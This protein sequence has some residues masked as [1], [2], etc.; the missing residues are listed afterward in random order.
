MKVSGLDAASVE[1]F[2]HGVPCGSKIAMEVHSNALTLREGCL[3]E[4]CKSGSTRK[5]SLRNQ[6]T[7]GK[8]LT[9]PLACHANWV[10][11]YCNRDQTATVSQCK[12]NA[13]QDLASCGKLFGTRVSVLN[14]ERKDLSLDHMIWHENGIGYRPD[15]PNVRGF[16]D[17]ALKNKSP[18]YTKFKPPTWSP[19]F[20]SGFQHA[21]PVLI[22]PK[23]IRGSKSFTIKLSPFTDASGFF[24]MKGS[25]CYR[26]NAP[27]SHVEVPFFDDIQREVN[28]PKGS[29]F[30]LTFW[31]KPPFEGQ[32]CATS[33]VQFS[34]KPPLPTPETERRARTRAAAQKA[35]ADKAAAQKAAAQKA[36]ADK[37]AADKA[38]AD[39]A[40]ADKAEKSALAAQ[41]KSACAADKK[42]QCGQWKRW[43]TSKWKDWMIRNCQ[44]TC[45]AAAMDC[46]LDQ[47][48]DGVAKC[49]T[50]KASCHRGS[51]ASWLRKRC[52]KT[53]CTGGCCVAV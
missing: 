52:P 36:A 8:K 12:S 47:C 4:V 22:K 15:D 18:P 33:S 51:W 40:A 23:H 21:G 14:D 1:S 30:T 39:K 27:G 38:A 29:R 16:V 19:K 46:K 44:S 9:K 49:G 11:P 13:F 41:K 42:W 6:Y 26:S 50:W 2:A 45:A 32:D 24:P 35:A 25:R 20:H 7:T 28:V 31:W 10:L 37:A 17:A 34:S 43:C 53:C 48:A 3:D 5:C